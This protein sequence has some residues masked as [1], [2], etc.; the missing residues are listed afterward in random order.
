[1]NDYEIDL[2]SELIQLFFA[3]YFAIDDEQTDNVNNLT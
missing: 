2:T 1:M 3:G